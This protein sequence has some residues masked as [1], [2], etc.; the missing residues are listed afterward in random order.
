MKKSAA[1]GGGSKNEAGSWSGASSE[2]CRLSGLAGFE[3]TRPLAEAAA[4]FL[5][6]ALAGALFFASFA[7]V[8]ALP[9]EASA[10]AV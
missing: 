3:P 8:D 9:G 6:P 7:M 5:A 1:S 4:P 10:R 2:A